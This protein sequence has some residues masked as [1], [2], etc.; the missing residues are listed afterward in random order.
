MKKLLCMI[1]AAVLCMGL[2]IPVA[3]EEAE[4]PAAAGEVVQDI[5]NYLWEI[6]EDASDEEFIKLME[7]NFR[8]IQAFELL[9]TEESYDAYSKVYSRQYKRTKT[10]E[11][12]Q[13]VVEAQALLVQHTS[14]ED[15]AWFL[16][17]TDETDNANGY[18]WFTGSIGP[19]V[20][21]EEAELTEEALDGSAMDGYG[22]GPVLIKCLLEDPTQAKGNIVVISGGGYTQRSNPAEGYAAVP[23]FNDLG[24]NC[25]LLQRRVEPYSVNDIA[26]DLQRAIRLVRYYA[27]E[28]GWGGQDMIAAAGFSGGGSTICAQ[29]S[30]AYGAMTPADEGASSY[31][32]D[33]I[34][35]LDSDLDAALLA[36]GAA[37]S[38]ETENTEIPALYITCG[39]EDEWAVPNSEALYEQYKDIVPCQLYIVEGAGHGFGVGQASTVPEGCAQWPIQADAFMQENLG[40]SAK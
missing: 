14:I 20:D 28:E 22:Q 34:D 24:Y 32:A 11:D 39:T 30:M 10:L 15:G 6:P 19:V 31:I 8:I 4:A 21:D 23:C 2:M 7:R 25:F 29:I 9:F 3:A 12:A 33:E 18:A 13:K 17:G 1:I 35:A 27:A 40:F 26:M 5:G 37:S 38:F 36:Y 16:W